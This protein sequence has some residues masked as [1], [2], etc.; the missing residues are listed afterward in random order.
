[1]ARKTSRKLLDR[2]H[3]AQLEVRA[4]TKLYCPKDMH[5][6]EK[7]ILAGKMRSSQGN[8]SKLCMQRTRRKHDG[9]FTVR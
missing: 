4:T 1:M 5:E 3:V 6:H 8:W 9:S 2:R 7:Q